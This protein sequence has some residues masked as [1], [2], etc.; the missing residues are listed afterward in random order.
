MASSKNLKNEILKT[1]AYSCVF[2]YPLSFYQICTYLGCKCNYRDLIKA[3]RELKRKRKISQ[4]GGKYYIP[5]K[6]TE[7][8]YEKLKETIRKTDQTRGILKHLEKIP[9]IKLIAI[10]GPLAAANPQEKGDIDVFIVAQ[11]GRLWLTRLFVVLYLKALNKYRTDKSS[12]NKICPNL[13]VSEDNMLWE[14]KKQNLY[15]ASE[16]VR[17]QPIINREK[18]YERFLTKNRWVEKFFPNFIFK[19]TAN[20]KRHSTNILDLLEKLSYKLQKA[21]MSSKITTED[22]DNK[23]IHFNKN[24]KTDE[25]LSKYKDNLAKIIKAIDN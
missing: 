4:K 25:I 6:R 22:I 16:I 18:T 8:W 20:E 24:D 5:Q 15:V 13:L 9:W 2:K 11:S 3:L 10:T 7:N 23:M 21:Y 17:M 19:K 1:L 14:K 12:V